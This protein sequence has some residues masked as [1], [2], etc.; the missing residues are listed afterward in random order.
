[1]DDSKMLRNEKMTFSPWFRGIMQHGGF[2]WMGDLSGSMN[3]KYTN[4]DVFYFD[5]PE[6]HYAA[7]N[8]DSHSR[9]TG[10]LKTKRLV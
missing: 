10:V 7:Y 8:L 9:G 1:M 6:E 2:R 4:R 5:P 3:G